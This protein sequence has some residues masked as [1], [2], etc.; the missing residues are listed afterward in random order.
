MITIGDKSFTVVGI[1]KKDGSGFG[2]DDRRVYMPI[3]SA[4]VLFNR[5]ANEYDSFTVQV[6]N[7]ENI[8]TVENIIN[9]KLF[10]LRHVTEDT[11]DFTV[12][13]MKTIQE[14][15]SSILLGFTLFLGS[16][17]AISL[18]VGSVGI[19]NTM[20]TSVLE[21]TKDIGIM[22]ALGARNKDI[23]TIF[24]FT[25]GFIGLVG[26]IIGALFGICI[27]L[28]IPKLGVGFSSNEPITTSISFTFILIILIFS[29]VLGM[30]SGVIP[31]YR[32]SKLNPVDAL[33][34]E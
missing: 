31:A 3:N 4:K 27:A 7:P 32:A 29:V 1:L 22:K 26:G 16:I 19:A 9:Q 30:I 6:K 18:L 15:V 23:L 34:Y 33:R 5:S 11:K 28:L 14:T 13:S 20:F 24:L 17:A 25:S 21:K 10:T 2:M 12:V 8:N